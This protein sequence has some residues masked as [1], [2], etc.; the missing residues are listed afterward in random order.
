MT[1]PRAA[2]VLMMTLVVMAICTMLVAGQVTA[3]VARQRAMRQGE[4]Q[5]QAFWLAE[6]ARERAHVRLQLD[7]EYAGET[8]SPPVAE[9]SAA[10][11]QEAIITVLPAARAETEGTESRVIRIEAR[12]G[13]AE[14]SRSARYLVEESL[15]GAKP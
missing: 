9:N 11:P 5:R 2:V 15:S 3:I 12:V 8:W 4:L 1:K 7:G 6:S 13:K 10:T 14:S